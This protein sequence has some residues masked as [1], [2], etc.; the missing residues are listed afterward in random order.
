[1]SLM[2]RLLDSDTILEIAAQFGWFKCYGV[3][4][5]IQK[6]EVRF[7]LKKLVGFV[8][9]SKYSRPYMYSCR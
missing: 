6:R 5:S 8:V 3:W 1:M 4:L 7:E 2:I 9:L